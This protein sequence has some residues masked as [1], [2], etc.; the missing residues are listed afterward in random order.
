MSQRKVTRRSFVQG[1]VAAAA[2]LA[3]GVLPRIATA[4]TAS[5]NSK[6]NIAAI[7]AGGMGRSDLNNCRGENVVA[8]CDVDWRFLGKVGKGGVQ[9]A[10]A[11]QSF[12]AF[13]KARLYKDFRELLEKEKLD[14]VTISTPDHTHAVAAMAAMS[15]G[16][17][18]YVQKPMAHTIAEARM[19]ARAAKKYNVKTQMGNQGHCADGTRKL[20]EM[21]WNGDIGQ[22]REV[23]FWTDNPQWKPNHG[24]PKATPHIPQELDWYLWLSVAPDRPY[25]PAYVPGRWRDWHDFGGGSIGDMGCHVCDAANW[26]LRLYESGPTS[27][28]ALINEGMTDENYPRKERVRWEFPARGD[29]APVT[30][31][32]HDGGLNLTAIE[33]L[34]AAAKIVAGLDAR[35]R[36]AGFSLLVGDKGAATVGGFGTNPRLLPDDRMADYR[37]PDETIPRVPEMN[38]VQ[39]W[40]NAIKNGGEPC[41]NFG[42]SGPFTEWVNLG[43]LSLFHEGKLKWDSKNLKVTNNQKA[44]HDV[45]REYREGWDP[46]QFA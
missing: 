35:G 8:I 20:C 22:V 6:L 7:G 42:I 12:S 28:E 31:Y 17:H 45:T 23:H 21:I 2:G 5:P 9:R 15:L 1:S 19:L 30:A 16:I 46:A 43:N 25:H 38:P 41:S 13:P 39:D 36:D 11:A 27:V 24:R 32:W 10:G 44:N 26:A 3:S 40:I 4:R 34:P 29:L 37:F 33:G 18:V 14:A